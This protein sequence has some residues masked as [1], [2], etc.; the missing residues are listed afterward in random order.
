MT[1]RLMRMKL[2][3]DLNYLRRQYEQKWEQF[4]KSFNRNSKITNL[5]W[6]IF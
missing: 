6:N 1:S 2:N 5:T 3:K 4:A